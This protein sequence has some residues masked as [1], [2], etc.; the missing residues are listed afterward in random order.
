MAHSIVDTREL[1]FIFLLCL[2]TTSQKRHKMHFLGVLFL[3]DL[4][5]SD[6]E[7]GDNKIID[8]RFNITLV[9]TT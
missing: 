1:G 8:N 9:F 3:K 5:I 2:I 4:A 6:T 7:K